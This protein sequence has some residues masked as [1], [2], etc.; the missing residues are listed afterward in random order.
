MLPASSLPSV[1][2]FTPAP[3]TIHSGLDLLAPAATAGSSL[4]LP[5]P[6]VGLEPPQPA[7]TA[8]GPFNPAASLPP[9]VAKCILELEFVEMSEMTVD[10]DAPQTP[11]LPQAPVRL[12][13]TDISQW[14]EK[15]SLMAAVLATRFPEKVPEL[16]AYQATIVWAE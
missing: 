1:P 14:L 9:K 7:I 12:P 11:G 13:L 15:Y 6:T 8:P 3:T 2:V 5:T 16:F 4:S 10:N